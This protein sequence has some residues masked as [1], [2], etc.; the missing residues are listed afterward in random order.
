VEDFFW[1]M[2]VIFFVVAPMIEK[3][4]KGRTRGQPPAGGLPDDP[5]LVLTPH[6]GGCSYEVKTTVGG[7]LFEK[8]AE[9]Y[10]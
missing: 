5:R 9:H 8:I 4:L 1:V 3:I 6:V 2:V 10:A 7:Q